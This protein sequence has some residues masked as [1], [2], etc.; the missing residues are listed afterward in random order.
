MQVSVFY[1]PSIGS[2]A[3]IEKGMAGLRGDLY[4]SMLVIAVAIQPGQMQLTRTP[5][6][7]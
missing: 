3:E 6:G 7:A 1:L 4:Q 5:C 2:R